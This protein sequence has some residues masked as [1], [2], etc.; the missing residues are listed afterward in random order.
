MMTATDHARDRSGGSFPGA[1]ALCSAAA[2]PGETAGAPRRVLAWAVLVGLWCAD[3]ASAQVALV[4]VQS[5]GNVPARETQWA[6]CGPW[7]CPPQ[8]PRCGPQGCPLQPIPEDGPVPGTAT[9]PQRSAITLAKGSCVCIGR[10]GTTTWFLTC[11]HLFRGRDPLIEV[12]ICGRWQRALLVSR[13]DDPDLALLAVETDCPADI[14]RIGTAPPAQGAALHI[15]GF[16]A[17]GPHRRRA[18]VVVAHGPGV[19]WM[20]SPAEPGE[21]GGQSCMAKCASASWREPRPTDPAGPARLTVRPCPPGCTP[22]DPYRTA[23]CR[24]SPTIHLSRTVETP[25]WPSSFSHFRRVNSAGRSVREVPQAR[26]A[27]RGR[28]ARR[29]IPRNCCDCPAR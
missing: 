12:A 29:P 9:V 1:G 28:E 15:I 24:K 18:A 11:G 21:S 16:P 25:T 19:L 7:G 17:G 27:R 23:P 4:R 6:S 26:R 13:S 10:D 14:F 20:S 5:T 8:S 2:R 3:P 22:A